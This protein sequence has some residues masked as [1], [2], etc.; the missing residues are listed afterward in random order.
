VQDDVIKAITDILSELG[1]QR[2]AVRDAATLGD[3][4][5]LDSTDAVEVSLGLKRR[6]QVEVKVQ[7]KG[8]QTVGDLR[9]AVLA[10][11]AEP[12]TAAS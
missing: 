11:M 9:D 1:V 2:D 8:D 6:F 3:E 10:A 7:V 5:E 12:T 4:L